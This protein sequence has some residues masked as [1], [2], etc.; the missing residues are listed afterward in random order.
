M[1]SSMFSNEKCTVTLIYLWTYRN[2]CGTS[3]IESITWRKKLQ[4]RE[5]KY[6]YLL[7]KVLKGVRVLFWTVCMSWCHSWHGDRKTICPLKIKLSKLHSTSIQIYHREVSAHIPSLL[8]TFQFR[9][10]ISSDIHRKKVSL[11]SITLQLLQMY[12]LFC[13]QE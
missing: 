2:D 6:F 10:I 5:I 8:V 11:D 1:Y 9:K 12:I 4:S 7:W 13:K 3:R